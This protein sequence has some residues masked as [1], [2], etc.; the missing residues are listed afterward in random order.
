[1]QEKKS[2]TIEHRSNRLRYSIF[3]VIWCA[4]CVTV[5]IKMAL[6]TAMTSILIEK[7]LSKAQISSII[8]AYWIAYAIGQPFG[9]VLADKIKGAALLAAAL[10]SSAIL[11]V[12]FIMFDSYIIKLICWL[13]A[14]LAQFAVWPSVTVL[15]SKY[16]PKNKLGNAI[17]Y[18]ALPYPVGNMLS[19]GISA[20]ILLKLNWRYIFIIDAIICVIMFAALVTVILRCIYPLNRIDSGNAASVKKYTPR[21]KGRTDYTFLLKNGL[22]SICIISF[23]RSTLYTGITTWI[24]VMFNE[25]KGLSSSLSLVFTMFIQLIT[26]AAIFPADKLLRANRNNE[27]KTTNIMTLISIPFF[28]MLLFYKDISV[29]IMLLALTVIIGISCTVGT[30]VIIQRVPYRYQKYNAVGLVSGLSNGLA[31]FGNVVSIYGYSIL[32]EKAGWN[33]IVWVWLS[34]AILMLICTLAGTKRWTEFIRR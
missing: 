21:P 6:S 8:S 22:I 12:V 10:I 11:C 9:G 32:I 13:G 19:Y 16:V 27:F 34:I 20:V 15:T 24:P 31:S 25:T 4:F 5:I 14:G 33:G 17:T 26:V 23:L 28:I 7:T 1:M 2:E 29:W 3:I 18:L 30:V